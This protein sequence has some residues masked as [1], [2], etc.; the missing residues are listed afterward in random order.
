MHNERGRTGGELLRLRTLALGRDDGII[1]LKSN[2]RGTGG[3][4]VFAICE[5][6]YFLTEA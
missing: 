5:L 1:A 4:R 3:S 2:T 6:L